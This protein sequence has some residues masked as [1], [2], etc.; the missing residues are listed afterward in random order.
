MDE[1]EKLRMP[2][3]EFDSQ[4]NILARSYKVIQ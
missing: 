2:G 3:P 1:G 4:G